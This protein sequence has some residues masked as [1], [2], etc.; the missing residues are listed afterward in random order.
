[1]V[2]VVANSTREARAATNNTINFQARVL[3]AEGNVIPDGSVSI[4][5]KLYDEATGGNNLWTESQSTLSR[6][7]YITVSLG[8]VTPFSTN[9]DWSQELWL[10]INVNGDGEMGPTRMKV[11]GVPYAFRSGQ[12]D[13]LTN[14]SGKISASSLAQL[15]QST[16]QGVNSSNAALRI[17]QSGSGGLLQL[18]GGGSDVFTVSNTG[19]VVAAG[20]L[21]V[22]NSSSAVAGTIRWNGVSFEGYNGSEWAPLGGV[23]DSSAT[24]SFVSGLANVPSNRT[25]LAVEM[26]VFTSATAVSNTAGVTGYT[27]PADG[28]F[29]TC[30]VKNNAAITAGTL[31]L[32]WV[33]NGVSVGSPACTMDSTNNRQSAS[34]LNEGEVT[35]K[36]GDTIGIAF[37]TSSGFLPTGSNDFTVYWTVQYKGGPASGGSGGSTLQ[38]A[39]NNS[40]A[41]TIQTTNNKDIKFTLADTDIDSNFLI[42]IASGSS[43]KFAVQNNGSDIFRVS[44][45]GDVMANRGISLGHSDSTVAGTLRWTGT[46]FEGFDGSNWISLTSGGGSSLM[47]TNIVNKVKQLNE[48]VNGSNVLQDDDELSFAIGPNEEWSYR[49]IVHAS[50][51]TTPDLQFAVTA[52]S[53]ATCAVGYSDPE[54]ATSVG[55]LGCGV[56]TGMIPGNGTIDIYEIVGTVRNGTA[57]GNVTL[58]WAQNTSNAS[59]SIVYAGSYLQAVRSVGAGSNGQPFAQGGNS[60]GATALIGTTD[61]YDFEFMTDG[62]S[63]MVISSNGDVNINA[64][65]TVDGGLLIDSGGLDINSGGIANAG[66]I[67]GVGTDITASGALTVSSTGINSDLTL[68]SGSGELI[69]NASTLSRAA[70]GSMTIDLIDGLDTTLLITNSGAGLANLTVEGLVSATS[71]SG[72]GSALTNLSATN[73]SSGSLSDS[74]LSNNVA[75][76][77]RASQ[78]FTG[79]NSFGDTLTV[80][81]GGASISGGLS[82]NG[83]NIT[84]IGTNLTANGGLMISAGG[85]NDLTLNSGGS[86]IIGSGSL[87]RVASGSTTID[88]SDGA[89]TTLT[90]TNSGSGNANLS[91]DGA[92]GIGTSP[93]NNKLSINTPSSA[94]SSAQ[95]IIYTNG[96]NNKGLVIQSATGQNANNFEVQNSSGQALAGFDSSGQLILGNDASTAQRGLISFNDSVGANNFTSVLGTNNLTASR[97][98]NLPDED[99]TIC[100]SGSANCGFVILSP[101]SSQTDSTSNASIFINKTSATGNMLTFQNMGNIAFSV[102]NNGALQ[103]RVSDANAMSVLNAS[104]N[105]YFNVDTSAGIVQIGGSSADG[106]GVILVFDIKNTDGDPTGQEGA[107]YYNSARGNFRCYQ[108]SRGWTD[109]LGVPKPNTRRV[110]NIMYSGTG[111][112]FAYPTG[113]IV[114]ASGTASAVT[115]TT[116]A[117]PMI[118]YAT[119][120]TNGNIAGI[121]GN[122]NYNSSN[123]PGFQ[124]YIQL[125][126]TSNVRIWSGFTNQTRAT[127]GGSN[128]PA[129]DIAAFRYDTATD[130]TTWRCVTKNNSTINVQNSG[131]TVGTAGVK[132]EIILSSGNVAFKID[133]V[134]V[135]NNTAN[136]PRANQMLRYVN[137]ITNLSASSRSLRVG[138]VYIDSDF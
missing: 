101:N 92:V 20:G 26:L 25:G 36:A 87:K 53:G 89:D 32:R 30:L 60:F 78:T 124:T 34:V 113:D 62:L 120:N 83:G 15:G 12:A 65:L 23:V 69:L 82:M 48:V 68:T 86:I 131:V 8:G 9:I 39:Y 132:L 121:N 137:S 76:L 7:G 47:T 105:Q 116:S 110:T 96:I 111:T 54:G 57:A 6:N 46:D 99:G 27:A 41:A 52:P 35:F 119:N 128:N 50:S 38:S 64:G 61:S 55:G 127:I 95:A 102:L 18:Q 77:N 103:L 72:N 97:T 129:G 37:D 123:N 28:S 44:G 56:T 51:A 136:L 63:R 85:S 115:A 10:T 117:P 91:V 118:N 33:V 130:G 19:E 67:T 122:T 58:Q 112:T 114:T 29:R 59:N 107:M 22:G 133:G 126:N 14:G 66:V 80:T 5:F 11:T 40:L 31:G 45:L 104:G 134:E 138:W 75:L 1:V 21:R 90:L 108:N 94:D 13:S 17:N 79:K 88:L 125:P 109:C 71:F 4:E 73:I 24:A 81:S 100:L 3:T 42:D 135:C 74:Y 93:G 106:T 70:A 16:I 43:S 84:G 49:F 2:V 98:I